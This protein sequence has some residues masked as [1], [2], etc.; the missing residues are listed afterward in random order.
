MNNYLVGTGKENMVSENR[1]TEISYI[2]SDYM[3]NPTRKIN[4]F[5]RWV[6]SLRKMEI[7]YVKEVLVR[8]MAY[9]DTKL[10]YVVRKRSYNKKVN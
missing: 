7:D 6:Q 1:L 5:T 2:V 9:G 8:F 10:N 3:T 4:G